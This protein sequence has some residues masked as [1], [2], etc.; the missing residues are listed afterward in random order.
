M[1]NQ[2]VIKMFNQGQ[3]FDQNRK[4]Q[5]GRRAPRSCGCPGKGR[6]RQAVLPGTRVGAFRGGRA[7]AQLRIRATRCAIA[8]RDRMRDL[9]SPVAPGDDNQIQSENV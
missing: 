5:Q 9:V 2:F 8:A 7:A 6:A 4:G 1:H 3:E